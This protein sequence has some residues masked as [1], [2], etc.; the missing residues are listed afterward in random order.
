VTTS[1]P[2]T[3]SPALDPPDQLAELFVGG[4]RHAQQVLPGLGGGVAAGVALEQLDAQPP[5]ERVDVPD[6]RG[7]VHAQHLGRA[8]DRAHPRHLVG[9]ADLVPVVHDP[10]LCEFQQRRL[11]WADC[12]RICNAACL[13][14]RTIFREDPMT[15]NFCAST[16]PPAPKPP[17]AASSRTEVAARLAPARYPHPRPERPGPHLDEAWVEREFHPGGQS[18]AR[19][20]RKLALSDTLIAEVQAADTC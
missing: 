20:A 4:L 1:S 7:V 17:S 12:V 18:H 10:A 6:H 16:P 19:A 11:I 14:D 15:Q 5:L 13:R 3:S 8:A 9:G 2:E